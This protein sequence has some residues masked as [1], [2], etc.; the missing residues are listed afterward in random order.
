MPVN[1]GRIWHGVLNPPCPL[2]I[3]GLFVDGSLSRG[4]LWYGVPGITGGDAGGPYVP[5]NIYNVVVDTLVQHWVAVIV[6]RARGQD[7]SGRD[8]QRQSALL[9]TDDGM[10]ASSDLRWLYWD[11][12]NLVGLFNWVGLRKNVRKTVVMVCRPCQAA[13]IQ[14]EAL[15]KKRMTSEGLSYRE[16][17]QVRVQCSE[18]G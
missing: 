8:G 11:F 3:L 5:N 18:C 7:G 13:F 12:I 4:L 10:V 6:E 1:P 2:D 16:R 15:Y 9:Y 14:S 17:Q